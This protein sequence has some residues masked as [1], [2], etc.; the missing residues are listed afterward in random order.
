[1]DFKLCKR[2]FFACPGSHLR[3]TFTSVFQHVSSHVCLP[4]HADDRGTATQ[5]GY[6]VFHVLTEIAHQSVFPP[7]LLII[8][9]DTFKTI[10]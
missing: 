2:V 3:F 6:T 7:I 8:E 4:S 9:H 10:F 1:M 5:T